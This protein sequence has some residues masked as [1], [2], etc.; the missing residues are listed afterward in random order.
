VAKGARVKATPDDPAIMS[1][2]EGDQLKV[3]WKGPHFIVVD[4]G[5]SHVKFFANYWYS[6]NFPNYGVELDYLRSPDR[7]YLKPDGSFHSSSD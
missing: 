1:T 4:P 3:Q 7:H 6:K 2:S 5:N